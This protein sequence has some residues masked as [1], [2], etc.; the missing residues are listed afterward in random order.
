MKCFKRQ[1]DAGMKAQRANS[2]GFLHRTTVRFGKKDSEEN[3][4]THEAN[5]P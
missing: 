5:Q 1:I 4:M 2:E 3:T